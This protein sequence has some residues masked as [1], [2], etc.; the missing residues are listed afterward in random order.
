[1]Q[2]NLKNDDSARETLSLIRKSLKSDN[3][4]EIEEIK[5]SIEAQKDVLKQ[6]LY[7]PD[8]KARKN[9]ALLMGDLQMSEM[10]QLIFDV[11]LKEEKR[12]VKSSYLDAL[13]NMDIEKL[14]PDIVDCKLKIESEDINDSNRKH[15]QEELR[16]INK[17]LIKYQ[18]IEKHTARTK[19]VN[20]EVLLL[21]NR[22]H[23]E[24]VKRQI[25]G[26]AETEGVE[27]Q[28]HPLGVIVKTDNVQKLLKIR[29][30][31]TMYFP[32]HVHTGNFV[33]NDP[34][35]AAKQIWESDMY[36]IL[37][38]MHTA[39]GTFYYRI[40][41]KG[42][43]EFSRKLASELDQISEGTLINSPSEYEIEI[44]LIPN[45]EGRFFCCMKLNTISDNRFR[46]RKNAI[47]TSI[48]PSTAALIAKLSEGYLKEDAQIIDPFC[49]VG[50]MLIERD[51]LKPAR[52]IYATDIFGDAI[53]LGRENAKEADVRINFIHRDFFDFKHDYKFREIITNFPVRG[54]KSKE[55]QDRLYRRFFDKARQILAD[56]AVIILYTNEAG[57]VKKQLRLNTDYKLVQETCMIKK[58]GFYLFVIKYYA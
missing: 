27:V 41:Y 32:V 55:E 7:N 40:D 11:Y 15:I 34:R 52:E 36:D 16:S 46:Y 22:L 25:E 31:K 44:K 2:V 4:S 10:A 9:A 29:T 23:R 5:N 47:S 50:T 58:T 1:M 42:D 37:T 12:F 8:A 54:K 45:K 3:Y 51:K 43:S 48:Q 53:R 35:K 49:G 20:V 21:T 28:I 13:A 38:N 14:I 18:G 30:F 19:G 17:I 26:M 6:M 24:I 39:A 57:F 33:D 56:E